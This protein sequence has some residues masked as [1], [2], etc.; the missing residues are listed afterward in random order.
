MKLCARLLAGLL[1][2][3]SV[4]CAGTEAA[5]PNLCELGPSA[6]A[7]QV[8]RG[9]FDGDGVA[10]RLWI[11][12]PVTARPAVRREWARDPWRDRQQVF[13]PAAMALVLASGGGKP[14]A[15]CTLVQ[16]RRFF[17]TPIW[18]GTD[19]PIAILTRGDPA[20]QAWRRLARHWRGDGILLGTEAGVD[21]LLYRDGRRYRIVYGRE[22][23]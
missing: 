3:M 11:L 20:A 23:P 18:E 10:D 16:N 17:A 8:W 6:Q 1:L 7:P 15:A 12:P 19:K 14:S 22:V 13:D 21:V 2:G 5:D 4:W 9:D